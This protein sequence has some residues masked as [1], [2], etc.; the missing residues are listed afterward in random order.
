MKETKIKHIEIGK[1]VFAISDWYHEGKPSGHLAICKATVKEVYW[2]SERG[3][4][5]QLE[6]PSGD[7]WGDVVKESDVS[8]SFESI[9][10][11]AFE[12]RWKDLEDYS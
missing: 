3:I 4:E 2:N 12:T 5:Y 6:T 9:C 11:L 1:A 7:E 8:E 10:K